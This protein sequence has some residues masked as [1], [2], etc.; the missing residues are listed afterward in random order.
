[1]NLRLHADPSESTSRTL[2][3]RVKRQDPAAWRRFAAL[4][5]PIVYRWAAECRLPHEDAVDVTQEVFLAASQSIAQFRRELAG[6]SLRGWLW[7]ITRNKVRNHLRDQT[8]PPAI[9][10]NAVHDQLLQ[11]P[12]FDDSDE[13]TA[14][15]TAERRSKWPRN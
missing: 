5:G 7:T 14:R 2:L 11:L 1:M 4:Y 10:G 13:N 3:E 15:S 12:E 8:E 6:Q 9:G